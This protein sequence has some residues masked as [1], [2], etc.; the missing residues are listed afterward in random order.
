LV[1]SPG[2]PIPP[3]DLSGVAEL[4]AIN[5]PKTVTFRLYGWG[6]DSTADSNTT[7]LGRL[8][9]P[10]IRGTFAMLIGALILP[11]GDL[12]YGVGQA[13]L[14]ID[15]RAS[16]VDATAS[17]NGATLTVELTSNGT[18]DDRLEIRN[19]G[20]GAGEISVSGNTVSY[21]GT[22]IAT[23]TGGTGTTPLVV[24]FSSGATP[25]SAEALLRNVTFRNVGGSPVEN[26][27]AVSVELERNDGFIMNATTGIRVSQLRFAD[28]QEGADRGYGLYSGQAD[29]ELFE[30]DPATPF[31][32]GHSG[33]AS[34]VINTPSR[35]IIKL[36]A[37]PSDTCPFWF[38]TMASS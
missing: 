1:S 31:P 7:A 13:G 12:F 30:T 6:N 34:G 11:S 20:I 28:F 35:T 27:R 2:Y 21:G 26:R 24:A 37:L 19:T 29:V 17:Y 32:M 10:R 33:A 5:G 23:F 14:G 15:G 25:A 8:D 36:A 4:Q 38:S 18:A 3:I 22:A 16:I 9:G